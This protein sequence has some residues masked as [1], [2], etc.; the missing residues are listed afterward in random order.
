M[1]EYDAAAYEISAGIWH[2]STNKLSTFK[3]LSHLEGFFF[4]NFREK[5]NF[6]K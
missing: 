4:F 5:G 2:W 6:L 3:S 1:P